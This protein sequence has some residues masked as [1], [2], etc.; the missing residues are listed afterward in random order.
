MLLKGYTK[1]RDDIMTYFAALRIAGYIVR[2]LSLE[3]SITKFCETT[4]AVRIRA[5]IEHFDYTQSSSQ[6]LY[7]SKQHF[8][9]NS[10]T[11]LSI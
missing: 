7:L 5:V 8:E 3:I 9:L 10:I 1:I 11:F 4:V 6:I 2:M